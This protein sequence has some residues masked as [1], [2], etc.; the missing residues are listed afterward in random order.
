[1]YGAR[2]MYVE[3]ATALAPNISSAMPSM[4][5]MELSLTMVT[6]SFAMAGSTFLMA[7]GS[8]T[9]C[10]PS[11]LERPRERAASIWPASTARIPAR[12]ISAT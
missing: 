4:E 8:T 3:E 9:S 5:Q 2:V 11:H 6:I 12:K 10:I 1:M 7:W